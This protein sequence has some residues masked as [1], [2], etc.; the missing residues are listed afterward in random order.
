MRQNRKNQPSFSLH[1]T[2]HRHGKEL[3]E[4][5]RILDEN[6]TLGEVVLQESKTDPGR[7]A[8]GM[9]GEQ[10]LR[11]AI[12]KQME[13]LSY[14]RLAFALEDSLMLRDFCAMSFCRAPKRST[15]AENIS[16][17]GWQGWKKITDILTRWAA[18]SGL[19]KGRKVRIDATAVESHIR[20]PTDNQLLYDC[21]RVL[22]LL[23][24]NLRTTVDF[25]MTDHR[26]RAK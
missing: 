11:C 12:V 5:S 8:P 1:Q 20:K 3:E 25:A 14:D 17:I 22:S 21:V 18:D 4:I 6:P 23:L 9:S 13:R 15:L 16:R 7:G 19:E 26:R 24:Q 2:E 10:I